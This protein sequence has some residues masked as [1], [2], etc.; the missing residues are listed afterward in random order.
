MGNY[1]MIPW[2]RIVPYV[3]PT[4]IKTTL[5]SIGTVADALG[6]TRQ[7]IRKWEVGGIIPPTPFKINGNRM[8]STEHIDV[9]VECAEN[10]HLKNGSPISQ[11][12]FT[13]DAY[14]GFEKLNKKF[15]NN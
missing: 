13:K 14:E 8:Y 6:R 1:N 15:F 9:L 5:Y 7:T 4:G 11:T 12:T 3:S 10:A 2:G